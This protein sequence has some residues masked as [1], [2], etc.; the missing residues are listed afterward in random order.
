MYGGIN[1]KKLFL[2][3]CSLFIIN[4]TF[5]IDNF[6]LFGVEFEEG[7][8]VYLKKENM[9]DIRKVVFENNTTY[10]FDT[11]ELLSTFKKGDF[12]NYLK[13]YN[14]YIVPKSN[15]RAQEMVQGII[16]YFN[17]DIYDENHINNSQLIVIAYNPNPYKINGKETG[18]TKTE[19]NLIHELAHA[20]VDYKGCNG[21]DKYIYGYSKDHGPMYEKGLKYIVGNYLGFENS[22][23]IVKDLY[24]HADNF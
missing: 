14:F 9:P 12:S 24:K 19:R 17:E 15:F 10:K 16:Y 21:D 7:K 18:L 8:N 1:M 4:F 22:D 5:A 23:I 11:T 13:R 3:L 6:T 20:Y 2:I